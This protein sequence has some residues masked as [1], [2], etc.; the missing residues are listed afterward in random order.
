[1]QLTHER[2]EK[3]RLELQKMILGEGTDEKDGDKLTTKDKDKK[4]KKDQAEEINL[5]GLSQHPGKTEN[6]H[7]VFA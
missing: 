7:L 5:H 3:E 4:K 1:L 6:P 2:E